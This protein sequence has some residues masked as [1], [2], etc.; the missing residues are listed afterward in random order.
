MHGPESGETTP[1]K[2]KFRREAAGESDASNAQASDA[3][4]Q[5]LQS[6]EESRARI[7]ACARECQEAVER[8]RARRRRLLERSQTRITA[9]HARAAQALKERSNA[10][11]VQARAEAHASAAQPDPPERMQSALDRLVTQ[12]ISPTHGP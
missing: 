10:L 3:M 12:L 4:H 1:V 9:L 7:D 6:E 8:A 11:L 5:V 2:L